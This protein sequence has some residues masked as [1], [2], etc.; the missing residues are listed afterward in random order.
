MEWKRVSEHK[1]PAN[2]DIL[3]LVRGRIFEGQLDVMRLM[4]LEEP[5]EFE[6]IYTHMSGL[7]HS[8]WGPDAWWSPKPSNI[9]E[10]VDPDQR[11][12]VRG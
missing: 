7:Q 8:C 2:T 5:H 12:E 3:V 4:G 9:P 1:P 6:S 10:W 11:F